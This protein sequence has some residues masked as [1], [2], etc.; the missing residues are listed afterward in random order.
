MASRFS[1]VATAT[2]TTVTGASVL[3]R[4]VLNEDNAGII[5]VYD[6]TAASG[7]V[8]AIIAASAGARTLDYDVHCRTGITVVTAGAD[9]ITIVHE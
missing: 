8:V 9:D 6:N 5:T 3:K 4:I 2:T 7:T 1:H